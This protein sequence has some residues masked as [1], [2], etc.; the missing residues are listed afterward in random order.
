MT[1]IHLDGKELNLSPRVEMNNNKDHQ[2]NAKSLGLKGYKAKGLR[3]TK[4][5][6]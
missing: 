5:L 1:T 4:A 2:T 3:N 6:Y